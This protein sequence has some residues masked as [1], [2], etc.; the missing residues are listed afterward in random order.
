MRNGT[1]TKAK[2]IGSSKKKRSKLDAGSES[3][4]REFTRK[5]SVL[6]STEVSSLRELWSGLNHQ[7]RFFI[8][9][10]IARYL[11]PA[12]EEEARKDRAERAKIIIPALTKQISALQKA[13]AARLTFEAIEVPRLGRLASISPPSDPFGAELSVILNA[14][15]GR[16]TEVQKRSRIAY[17]KKRLGLPRSLQNLV[18]AQDFYSLWTEH[19]G[20]KLSLGPLHISDLIRFVLL[21][22]DIEDDS[23]DPDNIRKALKHFRANP[24]N[25]VL[26]QG[27]AGRARQLVSQAGI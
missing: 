2:T 25:Q 21:I 9:R 4:L 15:I 14:E 10:E 12:A 20:R 18:T 23:Y 3:S 13:Y 1:A 6:I 26:L 16:L 19:H 8:V 5:V 22:N 27:I 17:Q 24:D 7:A 11:D